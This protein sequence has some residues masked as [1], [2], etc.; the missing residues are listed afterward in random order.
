MDQAFSDLINFTMKIKQIY[1]LPIVVISFNKISD[2]RID[3]IYNNITPGEFLY[4]MNQST[5]VVTNSYHGVLFSLNFRK[6]FIAI[7]KDKYNSRIESILNIVGLSDKFLSCADDIHELNPIDFRKVTE[8][9]QTK[10][11][12]SIEFLNNSIFLEKY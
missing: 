4:I 7:K 11:N 9:I 5:F 3:K 12:S 1:K 8:K 10:I 6:E 2:K